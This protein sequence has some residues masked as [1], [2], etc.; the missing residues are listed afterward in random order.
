LFT[1]IDSQP[2]SSITN[3]ALVDPVLFRVLYGA[4]LRVSEALNLTLPDLDTSAGT[5]RIRDSKNGE[6]RTI[7]ITSRLTA[8]LGAYLA[9]AH[10]AGEYSDHVFYSLAPGAPINQSTIYLIPAVP[11]L[12]G[13]Y[14]H[15]ALRRR[16]ASAL[17]A[18]RLRRCQ[19][20]ALGHGWRGSGRDA[21]LPGLLHGPRRPPRREPRRSGSITGTYRPITTR[22]A[23]TD[24]CI[25]TRL[26][27]PLPRPREHPSNRCD[28]TDSA[29]SYMSTS[30]SHDATGFSASI[31]HA[32]GADRHRSTSRYARRSS[33]AAMPI[34]PPMHRVTSP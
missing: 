21:A 31:G 20:A 6:G 26:Q 9:A 4:G 23:R 8:T 17:A 25:S 11:R 2:M 10:P 24:R 29:A 33:T 1:A 27:A 16:P 12:P 28:E 5:L 22:T 30:R 14:R 19:P 7:P 34:P 15:P 18:P 32:P 3:K 13:R